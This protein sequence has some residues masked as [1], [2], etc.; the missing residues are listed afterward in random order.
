MKTETIEVTY[1]LTDEAYR[2]AVRAADGPVSRKRTMT[3]PVGELTADAR[4]ALLEVRH[5]RDSWRELADHKNA[6]VEWAEDVAGPPSC[7]DISH[8]LVAACASRHVG[9]GL[10]HVDNVS[11]ERRH[12][13]ERARREAA[14]AA[15]LDVWERDHAAARAAGLPT[16]GA[17]RN[18]EGGR[19]NG[20]NVP[21]SLKERLASLR[22][23]LIEQEKREEEQ[24]REREREWVVPLAKAYGRPELARAAQEGRNLKSAPRDLLRD[25][26]AARVRAFRWDNSGYWE[27]ML[28]PIVLRPGD[29]EEREGLP[30]Q[31]AY[32][33]Y[34]FLKSGSAYLQGDLPE[35]ARLSDI[36]RIDVEP[37]ADDYVWRTG[38]VVSCAGVQIAV[39]AEPLDASDE[40]EEE[41]PS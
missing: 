2:Q 24:R 41:E 17:L 32:A 12:D 18:F 40:D 30:S 16:H 31:R 8:A 5:A 26:L 34:D 19:G 37:D 13:Q 33:L 36:M 28:P 20:Y 15:T 39:L 22:A 23:L 27:D 6:P 9:E 38:V 11:S 7:A 21:E 3:V 4:E 35:P 1:R 29:A 14:M 10:K 25:V